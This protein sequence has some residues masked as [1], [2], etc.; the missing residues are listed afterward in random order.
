MTRINIIPA[1]ELTDQH[2]IA[3]YR[4]IFMV[5]PAL[6]RSMCAKNGV[7]G[8]PDKYTLNKGHVKFFYDKGL[9]LEKRY[10]ELREEMLCRGMNPD[11]ARI[12]KPFPIGFHNDWVP[13]SEEQEIARNRIKIRISEKPEYYRYYR[14]PLSGVF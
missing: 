11:P 3:E 14:S 9:Y 5:R 10:T 2:L 8:I 13:S 6:L 1:E 7:Y 12:F 4:E